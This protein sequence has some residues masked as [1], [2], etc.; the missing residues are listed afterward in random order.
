ML[1]DRTDREMDGDKDGDEEGRGERDLM[2]GYGSDLDA[3]RHRMWR[4]RRD[5]GREGEEGER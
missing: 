2:T 3:V 1:A 4:R 5:R